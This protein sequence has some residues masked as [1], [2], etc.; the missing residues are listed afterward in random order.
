MGSTMIRAAPSG[1]MQYVAKEEVTSAVS[2][3]T[4]SSLDINADGR[5]ILFSEID[6]TAGKNSDYLMEINGDSTETNYY[7]Q[8]S[9]FNN[10]AV[11][12]LRANNNRLGSSAAGS[13]ITMMSVFQIVDGYV[14][15]TTTG[16]YSAG[17]G[18]VQYNTLCSTAGTVANV[19]EIKV[20]TNDAGAIDAG[21]KFYLFKVME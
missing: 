20:N 7:T 15:A 2:S 13:I 16:S 21:S 10:A 17:S 18:I 8:Y 12:A 11:T 1:A 6:Q 3:V 19:T 9:I 4:F 5:Y 14:I